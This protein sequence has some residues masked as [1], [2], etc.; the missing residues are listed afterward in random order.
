[1][2]TPSVQYTYNMG[3][4]SVH[5]PYTRRTRSVQ[6]PYSIRTPY[7]QASNASVT[8]VH[9]QRGWPP[10]LWQIAKRQWRM[11]GFGLY[12]CRG[13]SWVA[14]ALV[15]GP[16]QKPGAQGLPA[17]NQAVHGRGGVHLRL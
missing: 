15:H 5:H 6:D 12:R 4:I 2:R 8:L 10:I 1:M 3:T 9:G 7:Q 17:Q 16:S 11:A 14:Y 13:V